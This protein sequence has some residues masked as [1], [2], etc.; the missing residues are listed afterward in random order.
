MGG[1]L[2]HPE[3]MADV[4][5]AACAHSLQVGDVNLDEVGGCQLLKTKSS[6]IIAVLC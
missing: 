2:L 4:S 5:A 3:L 6:P 1:R